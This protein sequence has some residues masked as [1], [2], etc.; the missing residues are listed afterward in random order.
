MTDKNLPYSF[1]LLFDLKSREDLV[2]RYALLKQELGEIEE[3]M[4][5]HHMEFT[6]EELA[7]ILP[8]GQ[9]AEELAAPK[10]Y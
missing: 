5:N 9:Q 10:P 6:S 2:R 4:A 1:D 8:E 7:I 3:V